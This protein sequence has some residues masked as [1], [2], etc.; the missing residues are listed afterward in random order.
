MKV[1]RLEREGKSFCKWGWTGKQVFC[2]SGNELHA[3]CCVSQSPRHAHGQGA[4]LLRRVHFIFQPEYRTCGCNPARSKSPTGTKSEGHSRAK[5]L[6][7]RIV[8]WSFPAS[9]SMRAAKFTAGPMHVKS[10]RLP[11]PTFPYKTW[12]S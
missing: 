6:E 11:L 12:P 10:S 9:F 8:R 3:G 5:S 7:A 1:F 2:P 4:V